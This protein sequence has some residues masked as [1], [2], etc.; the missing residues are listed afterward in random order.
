MLEEDA[1]AGY[2]AL[3]AIEGEDALDPARPAALGRQFELPLDQLTLAFWFSPDSTKLLCLTAAGKD[4]VFPCRVA[5]SIHGLYSSFVY[6]GSYFLTI[7]HFSTPL[8]RQDESGHRRACE[9]RSPSGRV[10]GDAVGRVQLP[11]AGDARVR[12]VPAHALLHEDVRALLH[13][14]RSGKG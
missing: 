6:N 5:A 3:T 9:E 2:Y 1:A 4:S 11:P 12:G 13:T 10:L 14:V 7:A 8:R